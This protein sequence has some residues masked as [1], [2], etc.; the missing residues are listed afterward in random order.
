MS[1]GLLMK[2]NT[3]LTPRYRTHGA[4]AEQVSL[5]GYGIPPGQAAR[6]PQYNGAG[7]SH[8]P[9]TPE[10]YGFVPGGPYYP[11]G[12]PQRSLGGYGIPPGV[13]ARVP[14]YNDVPG[15]PY[16]YVPGGPYYPRSMP[17]Q[18]AMGFVPGGPYYPQGNAMRA[19]GGFGDVPYYLQPNQPAT[20]YTPYAPE[21]LTPDAVPGTVADHDNTSWQNLGTGISNLATSFINA[22]ANNSNPNTSAGC[23][24][25][26]Y[27]AGGVCRPIPASSG[28]VS[29]WL[30]GGLAVG[31]ALFL[32]RKR[33]A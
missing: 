3:P 19:L 12:F 1:F 6:V 29:P 33:S 20:G 7:A 10:T 15:F 21:T 26:Y 23:P 16:G 4:T 22:F 14:Q 28:G 2:D 9:G 32:S 31:A 5:G 25:G 17:V 11:R 27:N 30:L 8:L 18:R 13:A 24:A